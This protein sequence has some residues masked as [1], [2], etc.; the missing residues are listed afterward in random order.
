MS[1]F[2][3]EEFLVEELEVVEEQLFFGCRNEVLVDEGVRKLLLVVA[4]FVLV[5]VEGVVGGDVGRGHLAG[6]D[7]FAVDPTQP[8]VE[9]DLLESLHG[10][11][12]HF[13]VLVQQP[14]Q[15]ALDLGG[16]LYMVGEGQLLVNNGAPDLFLVAGVEGGQPSDQLVEESAEG[17]E[18][19]PVG[20]SRLLDHFGGHVLGGPAE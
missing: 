5:E 2:S 16:Q 12:P 19:N 11:D 7:G 8:G 4:E 1:D 10:A 18:V 15:E 9:E 20:V 3:S 13:L 6:E 17:V 14:P